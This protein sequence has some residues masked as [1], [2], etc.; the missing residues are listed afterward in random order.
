[1]RCCINPPLVGTDCRRAD[2]G[3]LSQSVLRQTALDAMLP[4]E[5]CKTERRGASV[6]PF[7]IAW[8]RL[9]LMRWS[10]PVRRLES[11]EPARPLIVLRRGLR[12]IERRCC[13]VASS[14]SPSMPL[15]G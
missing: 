12:R 15:P 2:S 5:G 1:M 8:Q 13:F 11:D 14:C 10:S 7:L 6:L 9:C 3:C 4:E